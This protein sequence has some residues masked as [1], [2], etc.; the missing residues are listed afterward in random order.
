[1]GAE[2]FQ[3]VNAGYAQEL[4]ERYLTDP[5]SVDAETRR[6]FATW[7]PDT[8]AAEPAAAQS[9]AQLRVA[10]GAANLAE[11]IRRYGH[12]AAHLDPLGNEPPGD[13]SL[14]PAAHGISEAELRELP[15]SLIG[16]AVSNGASTA[17]EA[18]ERLR[19]IYLSLIHI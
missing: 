12:L 17:A 19:G 9:P 15:A 2:Q 1:M 11:S 10:V 5:D 6:I 18:I 13:P 4:Y 7:T 16:G 3:G 14:S 8:A